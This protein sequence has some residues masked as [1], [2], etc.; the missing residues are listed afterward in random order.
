MVARGTQRADRV[1]EQDPLMKVI[2]DLDDFR[3]HHLEE[4]KVLQGVCRALSTVPPSKVMEIL[5][6]LIRRHMRVGTR[7][8]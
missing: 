2:Q 6:E 5:G 8:K 3:R 7:K 4:R 1:W